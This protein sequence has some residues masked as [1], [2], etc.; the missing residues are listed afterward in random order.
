MGLIKSMSSGGPA[1][2]PRGGSWQRCAGCPVPDYAQTIEAVEASTRGLVGARCLSLDSTAGRRRPPRL[3]AVG[4]HG[5]RL[6]PPQA[7]A[8]SRAA[9]DAPRSEPARFTPRASACSWSKV[10]AD[11]NCGVTPGT[12]VSVAPFSRAHAEHERSALASPGSGA[13]MSAGVPT[14]GTTAR[15]DH[16]VT[17]TGTASQDLLD[18]TM[19]R[20]M[21]S[22]T[23]LV[24]VGRGSVVDEEEV[25]GTLEGEGNSQAT[26]PTCLPW[27]T[28]RC[29]TARR[30]F[31]SGYS[32][33]RLR[34][35]PRIS[36]PPSTPYDAGC[37]SRP[38]AKPVKRWR[39]NARTTPCTSPQ[40]SPPTRLDSRSITGRPSR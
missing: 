32:T 36:A 31:P 4:Q 24:N 11:L 26:P 37:L 8:F 30:D 10:E 21:R 15:A 28:G 17:T 19:L 35:I 3:A 6:C 22:G 40:R 5:G 38:P 13:T 7:L 9:H 33:T 2:C 1:W 27:R 29:R 14:A 25:A 23:F 12:G 18:A 20:R 34:S 39:E 16:R